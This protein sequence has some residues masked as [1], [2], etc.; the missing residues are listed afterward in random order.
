MVKKV[1]IIN[2]V[3]RT[4]VVEGHR[5]P[6]GDF[7]GTGCCSQDARSAAGPDTAAPAT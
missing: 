1:L 6:G 3:E 2:G 4:I 7:S 5:V